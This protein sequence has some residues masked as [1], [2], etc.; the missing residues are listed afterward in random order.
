VVLAGLDL[1]AATAGN[2][3]AA[4]PGH[5]PLPIAGQLEADRQVA[6]LCPYCGVGCQTT[7]HVRN[8]H[9]LRIEGR[10]GPSNLSRLCV[11]GRFGFDYVHHPQ[12]LL[13]ADPP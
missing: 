7:I 9:V 1:P 8:D 13:T 10:N 3:S 2:G 4:E 6:S 11:K 5:Q 12:R